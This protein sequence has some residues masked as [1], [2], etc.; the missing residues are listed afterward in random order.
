MNNQT[1]APLDPR[2]A[3]A[4][5]WLESREHVLSKAARMNIRAANR[6]LAATIA[7]ARDYTESN[8]AS[9]QQAM[10]EFESIVW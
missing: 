4:L 6:V 1:L 9:L 10:R 7:L 8:L 5:D 3:A 2:V